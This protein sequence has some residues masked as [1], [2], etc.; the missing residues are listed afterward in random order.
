VTVRLPVGVLGPVEELP[1][2]VAAKRAAVAAMRVRA[3]RLTVMR[4]GK[5]AIVV[6]SRNVVDHFAEGSDARVRP[7]VLQAA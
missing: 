4:I 6:A 2:A 3:S 1:H 5:F 7:A